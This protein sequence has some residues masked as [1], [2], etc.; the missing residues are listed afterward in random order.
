MRRFLL[1]VFFFCTLLPAGC[2]IRYEEIPPDLPETVSVLD[3]VDTSWQIRSMEGKNMSLGSFIGKKLFINIW[4]TWCGPCLAELPHLQTLYNS[5]TSDS[6]I[7][8]LFISDEA[9]ST[10]RSFVARNEYSLPFYV[11][12]KFKPKVFDTGAYP[13]TFIAN[14]RG[15]IVYKKLSTAQWSH[16]SVFDFLRRL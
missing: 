15:Q 11:C 10:V 16:P 3:Y 4:A 2:K 14:A 12:D 9:D 1:R 6:S 8:F 7:A 5:L 13:S